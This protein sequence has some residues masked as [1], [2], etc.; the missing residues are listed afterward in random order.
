L[1]DGRLTLGEGHKMKL[2]TNHFLM[3]VNMIN[4]EEKR[5]LVW[6]SQ[7]N[8]TQQKKCNSVK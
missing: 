2:D 8:M 6:T 3:N 1:N 5:V 4:I 7:A